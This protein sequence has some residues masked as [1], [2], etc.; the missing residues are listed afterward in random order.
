MVSQSAFAI[1]YQEFFLNLIM[2][3]HVAITRKVLPGRE[4]EFT[5]ALHR[6]MGES[7]A[8]GGV[9]GASM[10]TALPGS[11]DGEIG[12]L[13]TFKDAAERDA[14]Y[15]YVQFK[16]WEAYAST[17]THTPVYRELNGLEAW[18]RSPVP[19]PR[20]KMALVTLCGVFPTS[21]F[22]ALTVAPLLQTSPMW[23]RLVV[24]ASLMVAILTWIIMPLLTKILKKW[25][26]KA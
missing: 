10:I 9:H 2:A 17:L 20:W 19:P 23:L 11:E 21:V 8:H 7:F 12:I 13:R 6:F 5:E 26:V 1:G 18:F 15:N 3:V 24:T 4:K 14:F 16:E 22:L 25:L